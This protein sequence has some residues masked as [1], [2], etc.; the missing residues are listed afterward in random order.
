[1]G[2]YTIGARG[3][4]VVEA[5]CY[6][7]EGHGFETQCGELLFYFFNLPIPVKLGPGVYSASNRNEYH[8][9]KDNVSEN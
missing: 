8:K 9:Q 7:P 6:K 3:S 4:V 5:L 1:V 2:C